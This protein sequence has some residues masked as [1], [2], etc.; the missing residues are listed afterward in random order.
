MELVEKSFWSPI[1]SSPRYFGGGREQ[2]VDERQI[3][4]VA[5]L[6][7]YSTGRHVTWTLD[8]VMCSEPRSF[9]KGTHA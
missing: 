2:D 1:R 8:V 7:T 6:Y 4:G 5:G 9:D 3:D